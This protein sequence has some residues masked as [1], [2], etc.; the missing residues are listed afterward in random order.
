M[1]TP[2][3]MLAVFMQGL[4]QILRHHGEPVEAETLAGHLRDLSGGQLRIPEEVVS[5]V[6]RGTSAGE[7]RGHPSAESMRQG[8]RSGKGRRFHRRHRR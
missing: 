1:S 5:L 7:S 4:M 2:P 3:E 8:G 6:S